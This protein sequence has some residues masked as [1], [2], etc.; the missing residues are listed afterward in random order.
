MI[1]A[2]DFWNDLTDAFARAAN[3]K[4]DSARSMMAE[5]LDDYHGAWPKIE[6]DVAANP[7]LKIMFSRALQI[8]DGT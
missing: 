3:M 1:C 5:F 2:D 8:R 6:S 7:I 4:P